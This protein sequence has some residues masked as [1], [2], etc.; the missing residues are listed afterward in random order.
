MRPSP[1]DRITIE[2][3]GL[4][5][6]LHTLASARKTT[7]SALARQ[8]LAS[9]LNDEPSEADHSKREAT[10]ARDDRIVKL[11][12]RLSATHAVALA[13]RARAAD[14]SQGAFVAALI[15]GN[16]HTPLPRDHADAVAAVVAS[17]DQLAV[18]CTD[19]NAL[20]RLAKT[21][22]KE[23]VQSYRAR[24]LNL[25]DDVRSHLAVVAPLVAALKLV[26]RAP[27]NGAQIQRPRP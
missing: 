16:P 14:V 10:E 9:L 3:R 6:R 5:E 15:D 12:L 23:E 26:R 8:A 2:L 7:T 13:T 1:R 21:S 4:R 27:P 17:T 19:I 11:T 22:A 24:V 18:M 25:V 20:M